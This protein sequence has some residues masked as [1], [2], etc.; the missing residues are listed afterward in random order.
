MLKCTDVEIELLTDIDKLMFIERSLRGG[1]SQCSNR[2][3]VANNKYMD[4][5]YDSDKRSN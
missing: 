2:H 3:C 5:D 1:I 4:A